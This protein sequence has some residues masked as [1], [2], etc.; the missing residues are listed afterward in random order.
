MA[1]PADNT[2]A[3]HVGRRVCPRRGTACPV[4]PVIAEHLLRQGSSPIHEWMDFPDNTPALGVMGWGRDGRPGPAPLSR[5]LALAYSSCV[6]LPACTR[7]A[8]ALVAV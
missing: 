5:R 3:D 8:P 7:C 6:P 4:L 2:S 1:V